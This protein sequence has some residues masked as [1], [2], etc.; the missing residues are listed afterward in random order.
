MTSSLQSICSGA[1]IA[2]N[3]GVEKRRF[4]LLL[5]PSYGE[6]WAGNNATIDPLVAAQAKRES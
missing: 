5:H 4:A 3:L 6:R 2:V 1:N